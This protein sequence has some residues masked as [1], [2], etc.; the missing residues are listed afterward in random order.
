M[1]EKGK[2]CLRRAALSGDRSYLKGGSQKKVMW[3]VGL[4]DN[5]IVW[6]VGLNSNLIPSVEG[7]K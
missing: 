4:T 5:L 1:L 7:V 2:A 3:V 6:V